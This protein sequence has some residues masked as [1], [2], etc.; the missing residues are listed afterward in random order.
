MSMDDLLHLVSLIRGF[1]SVQQVLTRHAVGST[2]CGI[3][4]RF[5]VTGSDNVNFCLEMI[6]LALHV[7]KLY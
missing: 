5:S 7:T 3:E 4:N 1:C 6:L 2:E